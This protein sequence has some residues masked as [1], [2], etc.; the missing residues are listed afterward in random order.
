MRIVGLLVV[1]RDP[2]R[3]RRSRRVTRYSF[4]LLLGFR[5][6]GAVSGLVEGPNLQRTVTA[7]AQI[8]GQVGCAGGVGNMRAVAK[9]SLN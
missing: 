3:A 4:G 2:G 1:E 9:F 5:L 7:L 6:W 8:S